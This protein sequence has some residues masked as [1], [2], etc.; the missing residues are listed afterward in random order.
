ME[1]RHSRPL[2]HTRLAVPL[3]QR[4]PQHRAAWCQQ[5][6]QQMAVESSS[7]RKSRPLAKT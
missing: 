1:M 7:S 6:Q 5:L 2:P 4:L 3:R